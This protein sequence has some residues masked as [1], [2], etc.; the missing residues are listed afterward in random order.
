MDVWKYIL[1]D[2]SG[3][4]FLQFCPWMSSYMIRMLVNNLI[5]WLIVLTVVTMIVWFVLTQPVLIKS[6][7]RINSV[8]V[9]KE[10]LRKHV[11]ALVED[12]SPRTI[13]YGNLNIAA[14][15]IFDELKDLGSVHYQGFKT[16]SGSYNNVILELGP[17]SNEVFVIG[18]HYDAKN[19]SLDTEGNA[20]GVAILIELARQ[21]SHTK[22]KLPMKVQIV[23]YPLS[24]GTLTAKE[25]MGSYNHAAYLKT[26]NQE[27]YLMVSLDS[28]GR[29]TNREKSQEYPFNFMHLLYPNR[30]NY[31]SVVG[32]LQ[33]YTKIRHLK[34][35]F[36]NGTK[37][38]LYSFNSPSSFPLINSRDHLNYQLHGFPAVLVTDTAD[39]RKVNGSIIGIQ[40][41]FEKMAMLVKGL[42]QVVMGSATIKKELRLPNRVHTSL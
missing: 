40:L 39:Y 42:N 41:D 36:V 8:V 10:K 34:K 19:N 35:S 21:L 23:A 25:N 38:P 12:Y 5:D 17:D 31:I 9:N 3:T 16:L 18:A 14:Q 33:D 30:G 15:Y 37:L 24:Q 6:T 2:W 27:V 22:N 4:F 1:V 11:V 7:Q 13:E 29:F 26:L 20:S 32:R 28:V